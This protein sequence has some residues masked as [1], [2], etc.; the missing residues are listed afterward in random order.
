MI[1]ACRHSGQAN[2]PRRGSFAIRASTRA[3]ISP[4][5]QFSR[6]NTHRMPNHTLCPKKASTIKPATPMN[7]ITVVDHQA[8]RAPQHEPEERLQDLAAIQR[9]DR[10]HVE[11]QQHQVDDANALRKA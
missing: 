8:A 3:C 11:E 2:P 6:M 10:Q 9:I 7:P 1:G 4:R 5:Q